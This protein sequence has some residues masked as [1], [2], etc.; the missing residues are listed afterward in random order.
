MRYLTMY[1]MNKKQEHVQPV[2][3]LNVLNDTLM[4]SVNTN[5]SIINNLL[6]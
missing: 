6:I 2:T 5:L 1:C 4:T 3:I